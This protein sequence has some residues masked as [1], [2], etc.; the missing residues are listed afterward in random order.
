MTKSIRKLFTNSLETTTKPLRTLNQSNKKYK[1]I[2]FPKPTF[3][4]VKK[5]RYE[6]MLLRGG[7]IPAHLNTPYETEKFERLNKLVGRS[8]VRSWQTDVLLG[9]KV[10]YIKYPNEKATKTTGNNELKSIVE[11]LNANNVEQKTDGYHT[12]FETYIHGKKGSGGVHSLGLVSNTDN[13]SY[14]FRN[15][16]GKSVPQEIINFKESCP[17]LGIGSVSMSNMGYD[18]DWRVFSKAFVK[19]VKLKHDILA[20]LDFLSYKL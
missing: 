14:N 18:E 9:K 17:R 20:K 12:K 5:T 11:D 10:F 13:Q 3:N 15:K 16:Y 7:D 4:N 1:N 2:S 6:E 8:I 19:D